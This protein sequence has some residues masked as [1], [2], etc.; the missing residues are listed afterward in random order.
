MTLQLEDA[1]ALA[2]L[3]AQHLLARGWWQPSDFDRVPGYLN[4]VC[5]DIADWSVGK[6]FEFV[7][8]HSGRLESLYMRAYDEWVSGGRV[9]S[10]PHD[11]DEDLWLT[12]SRFAGDMERLA[13]KRYAL[14][15]ASVEVA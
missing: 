7:S 4:Q 12:G 15:E 6:A 5:H 11:D 13:T 2:D 1:D 8:E 9:G 3:L 10:Q 14:C